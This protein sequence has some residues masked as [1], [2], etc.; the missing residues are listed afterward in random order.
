MDLRLW[1]IARTRAVI[2]R[3]TGPIPSPLVIGLTGGRPRP[4][5]AGTS[6]NSATTEGAPMTSEEITAELR[7]LH[8]QATAHS[9]A[10]RVLLHFLPAAAVGLQST[11][12]VLDD[13]LLFAALPDHERDQVIDQVRR[14]LPPG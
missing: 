4:W 11:T 14:L 9:L 1:A 6:R 2:W 13:A 10:L 12:Q 8:I 7:R 5:H 3:A